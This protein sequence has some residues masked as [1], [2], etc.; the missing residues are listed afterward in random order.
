MV[1]SL[2]TVISTLL[3]LYL[4]KALFPFWC[5]GLFFFVV[6]AMVELR[7]S[8]LSPCAIAAKWSS[9]WFSATLF[10]SSDLI[11]GFLFLFHMLIMIW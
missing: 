5:F 10:L 4:S 3:L 1:V 2:K 6:A 9:L 11:S 8:L 7:P